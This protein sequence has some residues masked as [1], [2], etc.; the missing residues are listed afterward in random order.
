M[1]AVKVVQAPF[2]QHPVFRRRFELEAAVARRVG[3]RWAAPVLD[4]D[5]GAAT[6]SGAPGYVP[7]P[8]PR[9]VSPRSAQSVA[10]EHGALLPVHT[11]RALG[12]ALTPPRGPSAALRPS[13][14][15]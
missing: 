4:A 13:T 1:V 5:T 11:V 14:R 3:G 15:T 6:P 7:G 10:K 12:N 8:D 2:A 9:S